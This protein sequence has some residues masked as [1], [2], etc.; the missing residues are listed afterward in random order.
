MNPKTAAGNGHTGDR[1]NAYCGLQEIRKKT[2]KV[3][4]SG[5]SEKRG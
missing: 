5:T 4:L 3:E 1:S 2:A